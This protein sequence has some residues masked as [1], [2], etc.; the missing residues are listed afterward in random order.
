MHAYDTQMSDCL[1]LNVVFSSVLYDGDD[2]DGV[3]DDE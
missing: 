3:D 1:N 2:D